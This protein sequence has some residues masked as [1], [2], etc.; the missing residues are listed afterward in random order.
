MRNFKFSDIFFEIFPKFSKI[1]YFGIIPYRLFDNLMRF[2]ALIFKSWPEIGGAS[3]RNDQKI[4][5]DSDW[6][7]EHDQ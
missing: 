7:I 2:G 3:E 4:C 5:F 1:L 6:S